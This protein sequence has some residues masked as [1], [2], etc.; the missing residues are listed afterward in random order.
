MVFVAR[1]FPFSQSGEAT[2]SQTMPRTYQVFD[3][4]RGDDEMQRLRNAAVA[5]S[6]G[7]EAPFAFQ[8]NPSPVRAHNA[9]LSA[10]LEREQTGAQPR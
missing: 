4:P 5:C 3:T 1:A 9:T 2:N 6:C 7:R 10:R 8:A